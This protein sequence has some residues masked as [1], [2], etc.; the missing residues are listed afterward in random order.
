MAHTKSSLTEE[1][2]HAC[3]TEAI[4]PTWVSVQMKTSKD[5]ENN[6]FTVLFWYI[7]NPMF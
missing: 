4:I 2:L 3:T 1:N 6:I 5:S 7:Q